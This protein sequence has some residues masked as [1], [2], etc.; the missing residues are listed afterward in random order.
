L[1]VRR[2]IGERRLGAAEDALHRLDMDAL[3]VLEPAGQIGQHSFDGALGRR[4][5]AAGVLRRGLRNGE[6]LERGAALPERDRGEQEREDQR[7]MR[8]M[9]L[10]YLQIFSSASTRRASS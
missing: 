8:F 2:E 3:D 10:P 5:I 7:P 9:T 4:E 1:S 6:L